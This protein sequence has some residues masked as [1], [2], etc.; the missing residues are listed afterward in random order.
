MKHL[1]KFFLT[2][3]LIATLVLGVL[4][5]VVGK[6]T[7]LRGQAK[8]QVKKS[9]SHDTNP[10]VSGHHPLPPTPNVVVV[11]T[12]APAGIS[13][14]LSW[15]FTKVHYAALLV[16]IPLVLKISYDVSKTEASKTEAYLGKEIK[17]KKNETWEH[18]KHLVSDAVVMPLCS[19]T[20]HSL[21]LYSLLINRIIPWKFT[22]ESFFGLDKY[23]D[24]ATSKFA[25]LVVPFCFINYSLRASPLLKGKLDDS[26]L[27]YIAFIIRW[28]PCFFP[29]I[30]MVG[31]GL[32]EVIFFV[33]SMIP[34]KKSA[35]ST[36][37]KK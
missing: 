10:P 7:L 21:A 31:A 29:V 27:G 30:A 37:G 23:I 36:R 26:K 20:V 15:L 17:S 2:L 6:K 4:G 13:G 12:T 3:S 33:W 19:S 18:I 8:S 24:P 22:L 9:K 32:G 16:G 11:D 34:R 5:D 25:R 14:D 35:K 1:T 28:L